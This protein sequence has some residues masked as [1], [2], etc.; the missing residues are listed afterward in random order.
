MNKVKAFVIDF[1]SAVAA[2]AWAGFMFLSITSQLTL[3]KVYEILPIALISS[4]IYAGVELLGQ[5]MIS[6]KKVARFIFL[7]PALS[8]MSLG[9]MPSEKG[10]LNFFV[11]GAGLLLAGYGKFLKLKKQQQ[12]TQQANGN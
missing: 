12:Q 2:M 11:C 6:N 4:A 1:L 3:D 5:S 9:F 10:N 8:L 7:M